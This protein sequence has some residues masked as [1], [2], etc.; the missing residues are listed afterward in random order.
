[1]RCED[2]TW[3]ELPR[4]SHAKN[5]RCRMHGGASTGPKTATGIEAIRQSRT[6]H[7][8]YS[9]AAVKEHRAARQLTRELR[10][11]LKHPGH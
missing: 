2:S 3:D 1:M 8:F 4:A 5:G 9:A 6:V 11:L 7:G 10:H